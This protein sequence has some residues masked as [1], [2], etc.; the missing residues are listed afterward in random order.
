[1][2][3]QLLFF[4]ALITA[5]FTAVLVL[6]SD[7]G[8][9]FAQTKPTGQPLDNP[10][11]ITHGGAYSGNWSSENPTIPVVLIKTTEPVILSKCFLTGRGILIQSG[12]DHTKLLITNCK[13]IGLKPTVAGQCAGRFLDDETFDSLRVE[14]CQMEHTSG[15]YLR[16][17]AGDRKV[18]H[19]GGPTIEIVGNL[20][21]D[22]DGRKIDERGQYL[23]FNQRTN[24]KT[25]ATE[26]GFME[27]QFL[28]FDG[29]HAV[30]GIDIAWNHIINHPQLS[31]VEDNINIYNSSG[32]PASPIKLHDNC[33][34]GGY[35][36][37]PQAPSFSDETFDYDNSYSGGG[38]MLGD[39]SA[40]LPADRAGY[41]LACDNVVI[42][43]CN[44]GIAIASGHDIS[45]ERNLIV[46]SGLLP[47][48][49]PVAAQNVGAYIWNAS[50]AN[51]KLPGSFFA[52][53][54]RNNRIGWRNKD[55]RNDSW[56]PDAAFWSD[57]ISFPGPITPD[58]E[59]EAERQWQ[60]KVD[61]NGIHPGNRAD[62]ML[63]EHPADPR[64]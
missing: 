18:P 1:M 14:H 62:R 13:G 33:I 32:T 10:L 44:Y 49:E 30:P 64:F 50:A 19:M 41:V 43:T 47:N 46:S 16:D 34:R 2:R 36:F 3:N 56:T 24:R 8:T 22:I 63:K 55:A 23:E 39:G 40:K 37:D 58:M 53:G 21:I 48:R 15:I 6:L 9:V 29:I 4:N 7:H 54:G 27:V 28:Q 35:N 20:A 31:R 52:N 17:F 26:S 57:N 42:A 45:F 61:R 38:I 11:V 51:R 5:L 59:D 60:L 12:V 25:G